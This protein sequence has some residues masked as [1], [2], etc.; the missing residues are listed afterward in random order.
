MQATAMLLKCLSNFWRSFEILL[1]N[2]EVLKWTK[3]CVFSAAGADNANANFNSIIFTIKYKILHVPVVTLLAKDNKKLS[4]YLSKGFEGSV[5][6]REYKTKSENKNTT[7]E[8]RYFLEPNFDV[9]NKLF[10]LVHS[11]HNA[12]S[13]RFKTWTY[14]SPKGIID[15]YHVIINGKNFYHQAIDSNIK[16]YEEIRKSNTGQGEDYATGCLLDCDYIKN[17]YRLITVDLSG[18]KELNADPKAIEQIEFVEQL[19]IQTMG[20]LLRNTCLS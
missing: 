2:C 18:Q 1:I 15:N 9:V 5:Y 19:K 14:Y 10:V 20:L 12:G 7:N 4:K 6:W 8:Y 13:K 16:R 3:Y 17:R 11:D